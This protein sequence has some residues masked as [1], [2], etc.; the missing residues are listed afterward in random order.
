MT[1]GDILENI[2]TLIISKSISNFNF[3]TFEHSLIACNTY[4]LLL[5]SKNEHCKKHSP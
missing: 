2:M 1:I 4:N 5:A 3:T